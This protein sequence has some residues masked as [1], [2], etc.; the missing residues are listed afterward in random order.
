MR[1]NIMNNY[2]T[3]DYRLKK[4]IDKQFPKKEKI[5]KYNYDHED[6]DWL[7]HRFDTNK[8]I[9]YVGGE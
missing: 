7:R 6:N 5:R 8:N 2:Y 9:K 3:L 4:I 1:I